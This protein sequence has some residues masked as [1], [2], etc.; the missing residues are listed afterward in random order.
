MPCNRVIRFQTLAIKGRSAFL[1]VVS[2][3]RPTWEHRQRDSMKRMEPL[4]LSS[5]GPVMP[6]VAVVRASNL[7]TTK[8][9]PRLTDR[10]SEWLNAW[11]IG[12]G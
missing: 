10:R 5:S 9:G 6:H 7:S 4:N 2:N 8:E 11:F 1:F 3:H 12:A